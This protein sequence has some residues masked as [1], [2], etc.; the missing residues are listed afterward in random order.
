MLKN[1]LKMKVGLLACCALILTGCSSAVDGTV[2]LNKMNHQPVSLETYDTNGQIIDKLKL[3]S[4]KI[5][6]DKDISTAIDIKYGQN[7]VLN[8]STPLLAF[9]DLTNFIDKYNKNISNQRYVDNFGH[10]V[11]Y[12]NNKSVPVSSEVYGMFSDKL[13]KD[14]SVIIVKTNSGSPIGIFAGHV[15]NVKDFGNDDSANAVITIDGHKLF[16]YNAA[17]TI[18]PI[19]A[20]KAMY[21]NREATV[22]SHQAGVKTKSTIPPVPS[23]SNNNKK[24][25]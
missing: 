21:Q 10:G 9:N 13:P 6:A 14:G 4:I 8:S 3:P 23:T 24:Q 11:L 1:K 2:H 22:T 7:K 18:Y 20:L 5:S 17:Y 15:M 12:G 16:I 25:K 19:S